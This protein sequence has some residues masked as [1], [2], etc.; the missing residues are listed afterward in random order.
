MVILDGGKRIL[1]GWDEKLAEEGLVALRRR[2]IEVRLRTR[3]EG[4]DRRVV[5]A[6]NHAEEARL[7]AGTL[8]RTAYLLKLVG[9]QN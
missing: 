4:F 9:L 6:S 1:K 7:E 5:Q 2:G 3:V 8:N